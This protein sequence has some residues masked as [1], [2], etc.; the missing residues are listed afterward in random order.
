M[1]GSG[2]QE[3]APEWLDD[4]CGALPHLPLVTADASVPFFRRPNPP[5][6]DVELVPPPS[7]MCIHSPQRSPAG[8]RAP[9]SLS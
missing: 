2:V 8:L 1:G 3:G 7:E 6:M 4:S 9:P 5:L